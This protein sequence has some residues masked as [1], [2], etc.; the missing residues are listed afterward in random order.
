MKK[1]ILITGSRAGMGRDYA[2]ALAD[3]GHEVFATTETDQ[4]AQELRQE[5][6]EKNHNIKVEKLDIRSPEDHQKAVDFNPDVLINNAAIGESGPL[7]EIPMEHFKENFETNV[8]GTIEL[9]QRVLKNMI[10]RK[11]GRIIIFSSVGGKVV[12][13]YLG[14]YNMTKFALEGAAEAFR[15]ELAHHN[16]DVSV[17]EP[18]AIATGFNER[19]NAS[20]YKWFNNTNQLHSDL[21][22]V[23]K[24]EEL[25]VADQHP[26][27]SITSA[28]IHAVE[29][30][31]PKARYL[32]P[33]WQY[34]PITWLATA[35]PTRLRDWVLSR[36]AHL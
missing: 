19:M 18:G 27:D 35:I 2:F 33:F 4:Q 14:T 20:K 24:Y 7:A 32:R 15:Q 25:L 36:M 29:S 22:R 23:K 16:I 26:T 11:G 9:T 10:K 21:D 8:F 3:R 28:I 6:K 1:K 31:R 13:P 34:A 5:A 17:I 12:I 30:A